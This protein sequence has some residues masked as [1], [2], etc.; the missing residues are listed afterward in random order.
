M[1]Q[2]GS[3]NSSSYPAAID[4]RQTWQ[5]AVAASPDGDTRLDA[6]MANDFVQAIINIETAL[7]ANPQGTFGSLAARLQQFLP[8][9]GASPAFFPF[10]QVP[11]V[12][13]SGTQSQLGAP[14]VLYQVYDAQVPA[15]AM[16]P[17]LVAVTISQTNYTI[18][19]Q[20]G[21]PQSGIIVLSAASPQYVTTFTDVTVLNISGATHAL[22]TRGILY[23]IFNDATPA[24]ALQPQTMTV[25]PTTFDVQITFGQPQSGHVILAAPGPQ[26]I[27]ALSGVTSLSIPG[28][29]HHLGT[30]A[31][32]FQAYNAATPAA[33]IQVE[34]LTVHPLTFDVQVTFGQP[35]SGILVLGAATPIS[36]GDFDIRDSGIIG[37]TA[38]R[39]FSSAGILYLVAGAGGFV[40]F[41]DPANTV[42]AVLVDTQH[43]RIGIGNIA[44][45]FQLQLATDSAAKP[46]STLWTVASDARLKTILRPYVDGL[47]LILQLEPVWFR[48][49]G[50]GGMPSDRSEYV[51][52]VAQALQPLAHYMVG[53]YRGRLRP[54][55]EET[56]I[57]TYDGGAMVFALVNAI[58]A[59]HAT[60]EAMQGTME[61][62][63]SR[64]EILETM[65]V[66]QEARL[67]ALEG[68]ARA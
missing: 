60:Q 12:T 46:G 5:N 58:K 43:M 51:G 6:E 42:N 40:A 18:T 7:G 57:L 16:D 25:H 45:A 63:Q 21:G 9:G 14:A 35:Q 17:A 54:G 29:T 64:L 1:S 24:L 52:L 47:E 33:A 19:A 37:S 56:D 39:M 53:S 32:L 65:V 30:Q 3:G 10:S 11:S 50:Q 15:H 44:P 22:N 20:F 4:T 23:Q 31:L 27:A 49:N 59:Q 61:D 41:Q 48:Y 8:G 36:G 67:A 66:Q 2:L 68:A 26:Y 55:D 34:S 38:T 28:T 62:M 13:I